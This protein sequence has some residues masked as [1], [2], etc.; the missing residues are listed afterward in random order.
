MQRLRDYIAGDETAVL[1]LVKEALAQYGLTVDPEKTDAD[2]SDIQA[3]YLSGG[4]AFRILECD[5]EVAGSYGLCPIT[6][7]TCELRKMYLRPSLKGC[8]MGTRLLEDA[9]RL[10]KELGFSE[11]TLETNTRLKE[12]LG[13]YRKHGFET[14]TPDHLSCR[15]DLAMR[16]SLL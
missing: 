14:F 15:C 1:Q 3:A 8:G 9:L 13:L 11:I 10:A 6:R 5:G 7:H 16:R 4:G 2:L 12:A